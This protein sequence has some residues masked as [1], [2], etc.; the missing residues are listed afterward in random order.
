MLALLSVPGN[1]KVVFLIALG[2]NRRGEWTTVFHKVT[3][4]LCHVAAIDAC[5]VVLG[6][7]ILRPAT[8]P[9]SRA[10]HSM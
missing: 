3:I 6:W 8:V 5:W 10:C 1:A 2:P 4:P 9:V 7:V